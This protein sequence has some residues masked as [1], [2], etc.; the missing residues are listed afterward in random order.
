MASHNREKEM[1]GNKQILSGIRTPLLQFCS[2]KNG[3]N[4][5]FLGF[6]LAMEPRKCSVIQSLTGRQ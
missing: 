2:L 3:Q 1:Q 4:D 6:L 5:E